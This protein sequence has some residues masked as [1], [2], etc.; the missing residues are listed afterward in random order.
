MRTC[1]GCGATFI[2]G[3]AVCPYCGTPLIEGA[4]GPEP[5]QKSPFAGSAQRKERERSGFGA[6][7]KQGE[8]KQDRH[9]EQPPPIKIFQKE[10]N[11]NFVAG[12]LGIF[13]GTF[14]LH[15]L[16]QGNSR[17]ALTYCL[18]CWTGVPTILGIV[19][20]IN[21]LRRSDFPNLPDDL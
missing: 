15:W 8:Y 17:R 20:G 13:F 19:E 12:I 16:Y 11:R 5:K 10:R 6:E 7:Y 2:H 14:G 1:Q 21:F 9:S 18:F 4:K 3:E